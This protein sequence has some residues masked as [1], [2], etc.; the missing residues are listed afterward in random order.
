MSPEVVNRLN[1]KEDV[2]IWSMGILLFE[3]I[4]GTTPFLGKTNEDI[5]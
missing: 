1:Y 5:M 4:N 2:D 3:M